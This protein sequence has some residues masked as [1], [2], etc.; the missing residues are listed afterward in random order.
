MGET[1]G[2]SPRDNLTTELAVC[3]CELGVWAKFVCGSTCA[4]PRARGVKKSE[5]SVRV[6]LRAMRTSPER[7]TLAPA[8][9]NSIHILRLVNATGLPQACWWMSMES[10]SGVRVT[11]FTLSRTL[12][13]PVC[14]FSYMITTCPIKQE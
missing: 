9:H 4:C 1:R 11:D 6:R 14:V 7:G 10:V 5:R 12:R 13:R 2:G 3:S 8:G